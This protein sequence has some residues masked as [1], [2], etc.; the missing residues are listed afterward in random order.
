MRDTL[1]CLPDEDS[2]CTVVPL[3]LYRKFKRRGRSFQYS[4]LE[5]WQKSLEFCQSQ[6]ATLLTLKDAQE[7][8]FIK[9][10]V[11]GGSVATRQRSAN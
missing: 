6:N 7:A 3:G 10:N 1:S 5:T 11:L 8:Y 2:T 4:F 9:V